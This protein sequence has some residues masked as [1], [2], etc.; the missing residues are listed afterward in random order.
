MDSTNVYCLPSRLAPL[1]PDP[2][3]G[4]AIRAAA[5]QVASCVSVITAGSGKARAALTT[6]SVSLLSADPATL[7]LCVNRAFAGYAAFARS[8]RFAVNVLGGDQREIAERL[9]SPTGGSDGGIFD[10]RWLPLA[11][12]LECLADCAAVFEC[13]IEE[14]MDRHANAVVI[15][16]V[17][18]ALTGGGSALVRWRG[19]YDQLG[20][21]QNEILR[22]VGLRPV[23][24]AQ[25]R[26]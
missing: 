15:G 10:G 14:I 19:V 1:S 23:A 17:L 9:A 4:A 20:W 13:E 25:E 2:S 22:A 24:D 3:D 6:L 21:S 11:D 7:I 26:S 8:R 18:R 5:R 16:R 12:D